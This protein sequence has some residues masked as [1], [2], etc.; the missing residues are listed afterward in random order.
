MM[1]HGLLPGFTPF[2]IQTEP[3]MRIRGVRAGEGT[4]VLL[5]RGHARPAEGNFLAGRK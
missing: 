1:S 4:S 5:L 3:G 2:D